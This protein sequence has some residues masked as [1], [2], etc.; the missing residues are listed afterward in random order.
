MDNY[1]FLKIVPLDYS[2]WKEIG[3]WFGV[4]WATSNAPE[5][6]KYTFMST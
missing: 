3:D 1:N 2:L 5:R 6:R 4:S